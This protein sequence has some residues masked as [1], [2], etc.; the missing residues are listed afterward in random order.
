[1]TLFRNGLL[2]MVL[3]LVATGACFAREGW[4]FYSDIDDAGDALATELTTRHLKDY[5]NFRNF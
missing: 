3:S 2:V 1:M 5:S 4:S